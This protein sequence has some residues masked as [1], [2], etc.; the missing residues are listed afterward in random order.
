M[1]KK[2]TLMIAFAL[3]AKISIAKDLYI[4]Y[5][6]GVDSNVGTIDRPLKTINEALNKIDSTISQPVKLILFP[7]IYYIDKT[8]R[9]KSKG[10]FDKVNRLS[11]EAFY[12]PDDDKWNPGL[13]PVL[14][15]TAKPDTNFYFVYSSVGLMVDMEHVTI[16]GLKFAGQPYPQIPCYPI[17]RENAKYKDLEVSQCMFVGN[18]DASYIQVGVLVN[19]SNVIIDH[20]VFY[21]CNNSAV[22][23]KSDNGKKQNNEMKYCII[24]KCK[25]GVWASDS[26]SGFIFHHNIVSKCDYFFIKNYYNEAVYSFSSSIIVENEN[27]TGKWTDSGFVPENYKINEDKIIKDGKIDL[28]SVQ[29]G[30]NS[31]DKRYLQPLQG[32][33]GFDIGA[34][35]FK[36]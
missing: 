9:I 32:T 5:N 11:I 33:L 4:D 13:M 18:L 6:F 10:R 36:K 12:M 30:E 20:C 24:Y 34:G 3:I 7:G 14:L 16:K 19:G 1:K 8:I 2:I 31:I 28:V 23:W 17:G 25:H 35:L 15:T 21:G 22:F 27:Y 29:A 26:D